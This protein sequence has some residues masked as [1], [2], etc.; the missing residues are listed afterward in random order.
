MSIASEQFGK[1]DAY[2]EHGGI[3]M[4][5]DGHSG[6]HSSGYC[7]WSSDKSISK[8]A[9]DK[10]MEIIAQKAGIDPSVIKMFKEFT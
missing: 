1:C 5:I 2:C 6:D 7:K 4:L 10:K 9:A 8:E 3:C